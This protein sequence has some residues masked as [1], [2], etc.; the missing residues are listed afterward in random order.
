MHSIQAAVW[1]AWEEQMSANRERG[2]R[3]YRRRAILSIPQSPAAPASAATPA[4]PPAAI[5]AA[6]PPDVLKANSVQ[7]DVILRS[8]GPSHS[9]ASPSK[10]TP[11]NGFSTADSS[12][13]DPLTADSSTVDSSTADAPTA[14]SLEQ[15]PF[16][17]AASA[18]DAAEAALTRTLDPN[19]PPYS[20]AEATPEDAPEATAEDA[21]DEAAEVLTSPT[22]ESLHTAALVTTPP[23]VRDAVALVEL[24]ASDAEL[25]HLEEPRWLEDELNDV[26]ET[27][28]DDSEEDP[29]LELDAHEPEGALSATATG[30][31]A[32][33]DTTDASEEEPAEVSLHVWTGP[34]SDLDSPLAIEASLPGDVHEQL[35]AVPDIPAVDAVTAEAAGASPVTSASEVTHK[36]PSASE[37]MYRVETAEVP[38]TGPLPVAPPPLSPAL[39]PLE[40]LLEPLLKSSPPLTAEFHARSLSDTPGEF[41]IDHATMLEA[42]TRHALAEMLKSWR[43]LDC[44]QLKDAFRSGIL[45]APNDGRLYACL[46]TFLLRWDALLEARAI[47]GT[48]LT[49][50]PGHPLILAALLEVELRLGQTSSARTLLHHLITPPPSDERMLQWLVRQALQLGAIREAQSLL[51]HAQTLSPVPTWLDTL[52]RELEHR[53]QVLFD[54]AWSTLRNAAATRIDAPLKQVSAL[55]ERLAEEASSTRRYD[56]LQTLQQTLQEL[57]VSLH[58][59]QVFPPLNPRP[60]PHSP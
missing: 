17:L 27:L 47:L 24:S 37:G 33:D 19:A 8:G 42:Q 44:V 4:S 3:L 16:E 25:G 50:A 56:L 9:S 6:G 12:A 34:D 45:H 57:R 26:L 23:P 51:L 22:R 49:R 1:V 39:Q 21:E 40:S 54:A 11:P 41:A 10:A 36:S 55:A 7:P 5:P 35:N 46:G 2:G 28:P 31:S 43:K 32:A 53:Q 14:D 60:G 48:G 20:S 30:L 58:T 18:L 15:D 52:E 29:S 38:P 59:P 13:V